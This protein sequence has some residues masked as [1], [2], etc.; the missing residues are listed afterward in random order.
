[1]VYLLVAQEAHPDVL[2]GQ[3]RSAPPHVC[4]LRHGDGAVKEAE[5]WK[6]VVGWE[7]YYEVSSLGRVRSVIR[8]GEHINRSYG[9]KEVKPILGS[10]RYLVVNLTASGRRSQVF[11]HKIVAEAFIGSRPD[12]FVACH[13]DGDRM[14]NVPSNLRWDSQKSNIADKFDH[15]TWQYGE[16]I[17]NSKLTDADVMTIRKS[18]MRICEVVRMYGISKTNAARVVHGETWRHV[19]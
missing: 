19:V 8:R 3:G 15:G 14:N 5:E 11:L 18:G 4:A 17:G 6:C 2:L 7:G 16:A 9:G 13:C 10:R 12:G 1:M